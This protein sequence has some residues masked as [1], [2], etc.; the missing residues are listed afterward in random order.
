MRVLEAGQRHAEESK[1]RS[2]A[3]D[4]IEELL[5]D[6]AAFDPETQQGPTHD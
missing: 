6:D 2:K 4:R 3:Q 1:R 5:Q